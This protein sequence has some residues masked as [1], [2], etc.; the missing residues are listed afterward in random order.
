MRVESLVLL[1]ALAGVPLAGCASQLKANV[2]S[3]VV[4]NED[5]RYYVVRRFGDERGVGELIR[6]SLRRRGRTAELGE[7]T[8]MPDE[9]DVVVRYQ[10]EWQWD[11][12]WFLLSLD[13]RFLDPVTA[14]VLA[15]AT[16]QRSSLVRKPKE[17]MVEQAL[18]ALFEKNS[19][20]APESPAKKE[21]KS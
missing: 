14:S 10:D 12:T 2:A 18:D 16:N 15:S 21:S 5:D 4:L 1:A 17:T 13:V 9:T 19:A 6:D 3:G 20:S 11:M 7:E 8:D